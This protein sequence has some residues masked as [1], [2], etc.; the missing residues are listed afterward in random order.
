MKE[1]KSIQFRDKYCC[2]CG[3]QLRIK[4][5]VPEG[6]NPYPI[7]NMELDEDQQCC[8]KCDREIV[9]PARANMR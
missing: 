6:C 1:N 9:I 7:R 5:G 4:D 2:I 3:E 8:W